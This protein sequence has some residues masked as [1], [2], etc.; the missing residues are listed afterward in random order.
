MSTPDWLTDIR[1]LSSGTIASLTGRKR[2]DDI[3]RIRRA[4]YQ[5]GIGVV[6]AEPNAYDSWQT[7]WEYFKT[8]PAYTRALAPE[9]VTG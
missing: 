8:T 6:S 1:Q 2:Y 4:F 5:H 9:G 7:A 3:E